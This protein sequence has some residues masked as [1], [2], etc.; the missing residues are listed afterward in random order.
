MKTISIITINYNN[1][2]GLQKTLESVVN[3][4]YQDFEIIVIDGNSKDNSVDIIKNFPRIDSW[5]SE[6]DK[7]IY[8][9]QNKGIL[10]AT[11]KYALF[12]NSGDGFVNNDVLSKIA[13]RLNSGKS[14]Y[15]GNLIL[16]RDHVLE[17]HLAP[18]TID[19]D[20]MLNSTF[21]HPC[22]FIKTDLFQ[23]FG[24]YNA[25]FKICGDYEFFI[26]C[27]IKPNITFEYL[28]EFITLFDGNG[29]SNNK[30]QESI[31]LKER[32][33]AWRLNVSDIVYDSLKQQNSFSRSKY[34]SLI[35][36][37]QRLRGKQGF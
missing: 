18:K 17:K 5:I 13:P 12:L 27:L 3:Q 36:S 31:Q 7:G 22:V 14:F 9:A 28:D 26:R 6:S 15:Y 23:K 10:R 37:L 20:F 8:D 16:E 35:N 30:E 34:A 1:A 21:W 11:G 32:E 24:A 33:L 25:D 4:T 19:L 2:S 29:I